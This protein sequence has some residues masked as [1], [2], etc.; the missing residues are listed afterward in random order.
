MEYK[1]L[2]TTGIHVSRLCFGSLTVGPLQAAL[3]VNEGAG[4]IARAFLNGV[5]FIDTAQYYKNYEYIKLAMK[6]SGRFDSVISSKT[7]A[8]DKNG[9]DKAVEEA[10]NALDRDY[11]DIFMLHE[12]ESIHT[13]RGHREALEHLFE[14]KT[15]GIIRAV[16]VSMHHI[17]AVR[18][19]IEMTKRGLFPIDVIHPIFNM[20]GLGI[21]DGTIDEMKRELI[22]AKNEGIGIFTMKPLG[23]GHLF[24][25]APEAFDFVLRAQTE[26]E[27][28]NPELLV[29]SV[30]VGMQSE[31]EV[32]SNIF[33][34][35]NGYFSEEAKLRLKNKKRRLFIE[36]YC[37]G[38]GSC[39]S[40]CGQN[41][42]I[43]KKAA[44][45]KNVDLNDEKN[46]KTDKAVCDADKCILCGY[47]AG[48]CPQFAIKVL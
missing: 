18:G 40:R 35:E 45:E 47:C 25:T 1:Y 8:Y 29:D 43:I 11:I 20:R 27:K 32:S 16:G 46:L 22:C 48:V 36:S 23:G 10:R 15:K 7:Y 19:V 37:T 17:A 31:E 6:M 26:K 28:N 5:N 33:Y 38:C 34:F 9:A 44:D 12:Q 3:N 41:S 14:L 4:V 24:K 30:A 42:I 2:G 39:V 13:L 21:A